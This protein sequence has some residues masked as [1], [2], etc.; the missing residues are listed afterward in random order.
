MFSY[1]SLLSGICDV[2]PDKLYIGACAVAA[3]FLAHAPARLQRHAVTYPIHPHAHTPPHAR[4][5]THNEP[6]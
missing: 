3:A 6:L 4:P 2:T 1:L 5:N